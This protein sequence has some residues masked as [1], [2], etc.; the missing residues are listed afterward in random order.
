MSVLVVGSV[1][2]DYTVTVRRRP[3]PGET[4][5][6]ADFTT[7]GGGKG[8]NQASAVAR[9]GGNVRLLARVGDDPE[10]QHMRAM[11]ADAGVD[12]S[13]VEPVAGARTGA[14]FI[15]VTPDG[16]NTIVVAPG[17][18]HA[19]TAAGVEAAGLADDHS[20]VLVMQLEIPMEAVMRAAEL[21]SSTMRLVLNLSPARD[22]P[23]SL[24]IRADPLVV[25]ESEAGFLLGRSIDGIDAARAAAADLVKLGARS[26]VLTVGAAGAVAVTNGVVTHVPAPEVRVVDT[27][28]AGDAFVGAVALR[29]A[30]D[31]DLLDAVRLGVRAGAG[32]ATR[33]GARSVPLREDLPAEPQ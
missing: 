29:L 33:A 13:A 11:L 17:A 30:E 26:A 1:N 14:A 23:H 2:Q 32:A 9:L 25:N 8:A 20:R 16:E 22:V 4:V 12:I 21:T 10:G 24:L 6:D 28:G 31:A 27:T 18:N 5:G 19:L 3:V 7:A 15:T